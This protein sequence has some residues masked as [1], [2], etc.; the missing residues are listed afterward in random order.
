M[1][2]NFIVFP[3]FQA[4]I[5]IS[6]RMGKLRLNYFSTKKSLFLFGPG[7]IIRKV[8][9]RIATNQFFEY[10]I[11]VTIFVNCFFLASQDPDTTVISE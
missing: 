10:F 4:F 9:I 6:K 1:R 3:L 7:N 11:M 5:V 8:A 2:I